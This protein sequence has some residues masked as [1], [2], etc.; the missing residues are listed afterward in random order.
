MA[1]CCDHQQVNITVI[2]RYAPGVRTEQDDLLWFEL[3]YQ[4]PCDFLK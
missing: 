1:V 2:I 4:T 3:D